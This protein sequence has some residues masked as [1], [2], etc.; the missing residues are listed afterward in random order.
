MNFLLI[1]IWK[2]VSESLHKVLNLGNKIKTQ[3]KYYRILIL[4]NVI[5]AKVSLLFGSYACTRIPNQHVTAYVTSTLFRSDIASS[6]AA[7]IRLASG[8]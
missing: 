8:Y 3:K 5:N 2:A 7:S 1:L 4:T 6:I